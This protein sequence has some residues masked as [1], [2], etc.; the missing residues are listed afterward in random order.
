MQYH[1]KK[2]QTCFFHVPK[3]A[4]VTVLEI[5]RAHLGRENVFHATKRRHLTQPIA[6]LFRGHPV[7]AGHFSARYLSSDVPAKTFIFT[8]LRNPLERILSQYSYYR[9]LPAG[10]G[11]T[12][13]SVDLSKNLGLKEILRKCARK[14]IFSSWSNLQTA[15]FSGCNLSRPAD[16]DI[17]EQAKHNLEQFDFVGIQEELG[18]GVREL[19]ARMGM[20][21]A[22]ETPILNKTINRLE[23][24]SLDQETTDLIAETNN[25]DHSLFLHAEKLWR[26]GHLPPPE[27]KF[28]TDLGLH[29]AHGTREI[30]ATSISLKDGE[31]SFRRVTQGRPWNLVISGKSSVGCTNFT[32]GILI[33]DEGGASLYGTN[34]WLKGN[35]WTISQNNTFT[36][37]IQF[38]AMTLATG[39]YDLTVS[40]HTSKD[41]TEKCFHWL[42]KAFQFEVVE[43]DSQDFVGVTNLG[44]QFR[45][46][47]GAN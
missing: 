38:P 18:H 19:F 3:T 14:G 5:L 31:P 10:T 32:V 41:T 9:S 42:E 28:I 7:V 35:R 44:A 12:D 8:F 27:S 25:L 29:G 45:L 17:F 36:V 6:Q 21:K 33:S 24:D 16:H 1:L 15:I 47:P 43:E 26:E 39:H 30:E 2:Q 11:S 46:V 4:G 34:T 20:E 23:V 37:E 13:P 40:F 22:P